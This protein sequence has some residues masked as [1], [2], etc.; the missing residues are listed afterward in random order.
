MDCLN[1]YRLLVWCVSLSKQ[2]SDNKDYIHPMISPI[3]L[4]NRAGAHVLMLL[5]CEHD[6]GGGKLK[7]GSLINDWFIRNLSQNCPDSKQ[8]I[9]KAFETLNLHELIQTKIM[10]EKSMLNKETIRM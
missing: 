7:C 10:D 9:K 6:V 5:G 8:T 1:S 2:T 4:S 3:E